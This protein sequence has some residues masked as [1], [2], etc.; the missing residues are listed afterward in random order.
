MT[1]CLCDTNEKASPV[2]IMPYFKQTNPPIHRKLYLF[3]SMNMYTLSL[4]TQ[5]QTHRICTLSNFDPNPGI[6]ITDNCRLYG[7]NP[8]YFYWT[9]G[10]SKS[11]LNSFTQVCLSP[12]Q[13]CATQ[14]A[15]VHSLH[16]MKVTVTENT[17]KK[18]W[19]SVHNIQIIGRV[20]GWNFPTCPSAL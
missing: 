5:C 20:G 10:A 13:R 4:Q 8:V 12:V 3:T 18:Q 11:S 6:V 14:G 17:T 9:Q 1:Q 19:V 7:S 2:S 16:Q 15:K